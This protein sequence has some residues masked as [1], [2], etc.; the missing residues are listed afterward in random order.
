LLVLVGCQNKE[1]KYDNELYKINLYGKIKSYEEAVFGVINDSV[2]NAIH[3]RVFRSKYKISFDST[4]KEI[5][6]IVFKENGNIRH[7]R[8]KEYNNKGS[9]LSTTVF[10]SLGE[11]NW[12]SEMSY[13]DRYNIVEKNNFNK[14]RDSYS[15]ESFKYNRNNDLVK[16]VVVERD[17]EVY[18]ES[19][20][21]NENKNLIEQNF[22]NKNREGDFYLEI[23]NLFR[24]DSVGNK[25]ER[26]MFKDEYKK[27]LVISYFEKFDSIGN[28]VESISYNSDGSVFRR[29]TNEYD[30][31]N[32]LI[33]T[34]R[35]TKGDLKEK[36]VYVCDKGCNKIEESIF[37]KKKKVVLKKYNYDENGNMINLHTKNV[38]SE[39]PRIYNL[40][41]EFD[42]DKNKSWIKRSEF[43]NEILTSVT[44]RKIEYFK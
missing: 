23:Q 18:I 9:L 16:R 32:C 24:Y 13:D 6:H 19:L 1:I 25:I 7:S 39:I 2:D 41:Y 40:R 4:G 14:N 8:L 35:Y 36:R 31:N 26:R 30:L 38:S 42:Y 27:G 44:E 20:V 15:K 3:K 10:D 22:F 34:L 11:M 43:Q 12:R 29:I 21:Y 37:W 5:E 17:D 33:Q 28:I